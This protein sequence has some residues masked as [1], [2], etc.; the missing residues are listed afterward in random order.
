MH[1]LKKCPQCREKVR[2]LISAVSLSL[3]KTNTGLKD[4][5]FTNLVHRDKG[6]YENVTA[7]DGESKVMIAGDRSTY[8]ELERQKNRR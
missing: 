1:A 6:V 8:P 3:P 2:R 7:R 4:Q 5:G